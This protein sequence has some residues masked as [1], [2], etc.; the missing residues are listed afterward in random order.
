MP[1]RK[2]SRHATA[3]SVA[4]SERSKKS[5]KKKEKVSVKAIE[6]GRSRKGD[7]MEMVF[8]PKPQRQGSN[9]LKALFKDKK[10][11]EMVRVR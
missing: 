10:E 3:E 11:R 8:R 6:D 1:E 9:M 5:S 7:D 4:G 2:S